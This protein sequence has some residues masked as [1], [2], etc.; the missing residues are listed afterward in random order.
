VKTFWLSAS[1]AFSSLSGC[2]MPTSSKSTD[3]GTVTIPV[4]TGTGGAVSSAAMG[5]G[6]GTDNGVTLCLGTS[7]CPSISVDQGVFPECG[8]YFAN[9][10]VSLACL[11]SNYLCPI[12]PASTCDEA[13]SLL[14]SSNEGTVC[15]AASNNGCLALS[16][17]T[18]D[19]DAGTTADSG[20]GC[21]ESCASMCAGVPDC[22][23]L[24]GC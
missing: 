13:M 12:G 5:T 6:C 11:C 10:S 1:V 16:A 7:E 15:G 9:G 21:D 20:S 23:Q 4:P 22:I 3:A 19:T 14:Q 2:M 8:F 24:C 18:T 17:G